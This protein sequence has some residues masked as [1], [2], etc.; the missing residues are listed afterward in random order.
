[1]AFTTEERINQLELIC[2]SIKD[3]AHKIIGEMPMYNSIEIQ[4]SMQCNEV[5]TIRIETLAY[6]HKLVEKWQNNLESK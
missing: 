1:M 2:D 5:P 3:R 6:P 4:I